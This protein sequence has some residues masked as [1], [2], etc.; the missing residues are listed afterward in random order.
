MGNREKIQRARLSRYEGKAFRRAREIAGL[1]QK[2]F[3]DRL[4]HGVQIRIRQP[5]RRPNARFVDC[6]RQP[7]PSSTGRTAE[8][9]DRNRYATMVNNLRR[10]LV[11][12]ICKT[13]L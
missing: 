11:K 6:A 9:Q 8:T 13:D 2:S 10:R 3:A 12:R 4:E 1:A 5:D 7:A